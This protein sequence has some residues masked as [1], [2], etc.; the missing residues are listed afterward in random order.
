MTRY[1]SHSPLKERVAAY[2]AGSSDGKFSSSSS[3]AAARAL[4]SS[5]P[6]ITASDV[7]YLPEY[8]SVALVP[9]SQPHLAYLSHAQSMPLLSA[10]AEI[11][12]YPPVSTEK[13]LMDIGSRVVS[14]NGRDAAESRS[15]NSLDAPDGGATVETAS[16]PVRRRSRRDNGT[17]KEDEEPPHLYNDS[18]TAAGAGTGTKIE[19][20]TETMDREDT[21]SEQSSGSQDR[22]EAQDTT[23]AASRGEE[24]NGAADALVLVDTAAD[25]LAWVC[26]VLPGMPNN[27]RLCISVNIQQSL[28]FYG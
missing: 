25:M 3:R 11:P 19:T 9:L 10:A 17:D 14:A 6:L 23:D 16:V 27:V 21:V 18:A 4:G 24:V 26:L 7:I 5:V 2:Y 22:S 20:E 28:A 1:R 8:G 12:V 15:S 13:A